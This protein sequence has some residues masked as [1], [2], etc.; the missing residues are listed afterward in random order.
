MFDARIPICEHIE[1]AYGELVLLAPFRTSLGFR[2]GFEHYRYGGCRL[3][4]MSQ[5]FA[6]N[7]V[8]TRM[9]YPG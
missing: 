1:R 5:E 6:S 2:R 9:T 3:D 7:I 8:Q 4:E